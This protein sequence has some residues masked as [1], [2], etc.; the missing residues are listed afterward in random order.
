M[1]LKSSNFRVWLHF[2]PRSHSFLL[3]NGD[4]KWRVFQVGVRPPSPF[5]QV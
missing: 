4:T 3:G 5:T 2:L 1:G